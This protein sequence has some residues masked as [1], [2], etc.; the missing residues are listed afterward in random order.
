MLVLT[1]LE[2]KQAPPACKVFNMLED[3]K[4]YLK[5]GHEKTTFGVEADRLL[6]KLAE[7]DCKSISSP[8]RRCLPCH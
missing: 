7:P 1:S 3:I 8:F 5:S 6:S 2:E 4:A